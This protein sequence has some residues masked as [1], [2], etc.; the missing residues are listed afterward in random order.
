M[1]LYHCPVDPA[2]APTDQRYWVGCRQCAI[3]GYASSTSFF[4]PKHVYS[5]GDP[6]RPGISS[7]TYNPSTHSLTI[8]SSGETVILDSASG[9]IDHWIHPSRGSLKWNTKHQSANWLARQVDYGVTGSGTTMVGK[10]TS[11]LTGVLVAKADD[12]DAHAY[13]VNPYGQAVRDLVDWP[14]TCACGA[15]APRGSARCLACLSSPAIP[16]EST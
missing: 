7:F 6:I 11:E 2:H 13:P 9:F 1:S 15:C 8:A 3:A 14:W 12:P 4:T 5:D 10:F 16:S